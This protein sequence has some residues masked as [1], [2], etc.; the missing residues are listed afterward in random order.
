MKED[1]VIDYAYPMMM[2]EQALKKAH[3]AVLHNDYHGCLEA[4]DEAVVQ[5]RGARIAVISMEQNR[6]LRKQTET[7]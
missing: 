2:A 4:L 1:A 5:L 7:V 3:D 6:A